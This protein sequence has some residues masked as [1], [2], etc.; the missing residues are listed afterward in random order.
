MWRG[1]TEGGTDGK[2]EEDAFP[3]EYAAVEVSVRC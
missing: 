1:N 3:F 2:R